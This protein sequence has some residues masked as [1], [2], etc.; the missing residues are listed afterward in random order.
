VQEDQ[1]QTER[2]TGTA[3]HA[4]EDETDAETQHRGG[5]QQMKASAP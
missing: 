3:R 1:G 2:E 4:F 5:Q